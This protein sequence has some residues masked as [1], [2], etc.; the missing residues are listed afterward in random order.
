MSLLNKKKKKEIVPPPT[1]DTR[2][3]ECNKRCAPVLLSVRGRSQ[4]ISATHVLVR[5]LEEPT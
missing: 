2:A 3:N 1:W 5:I 4:L